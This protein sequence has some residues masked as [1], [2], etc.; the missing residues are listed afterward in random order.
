M[1]AL[2]APSNGLPKYFILLS[3]F[4][5]RDVRTLSTQASL[6]VIERWSN[7]QNKTSRV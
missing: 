6:V 4:D 3:V 1:F 2:A 5:L 7:G